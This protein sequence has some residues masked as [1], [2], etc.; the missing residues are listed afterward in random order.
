MIPEVKNNLDKI[1]AACKRMQLKSLHLFGSGARV[2]DYTQNSDLDFLFSMVTGKDGMP[3]SG[4]D[5]FD[6]LWE[7]EKIT[8]KKVDLVAAEK[9][10]N[11]YFLQSVLEDQIKLYEA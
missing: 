3:V 11:K 6:V 8:G 10:R 7:L 2:K 9:I 1:I 4:F 5:Y